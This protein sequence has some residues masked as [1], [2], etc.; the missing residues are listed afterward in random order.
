MIFRKEIKL[1]GSMAV[2]T[3]LMGCMKEQTLE[4]LEAIVPTKE[5]LSVGMA[6]DEPA[7]I[8]RYLL[9]NGVSSPQLS[10][11]GQQVIFRSSIT[12]VPQLWTLPID[13]GTPTQ[14]TFGNG[15]TFA[16]WLPDSSGIL[17]GADNNG[18]EQESYLLI[19]RNGSAEREIFSATDGGFRSL[20]D[21]SPD[22]DTFFFASTERTGL[23]YDIYEGSISSGEM[24][25]VLEGTYGNFAHALSPGGRYLVITETV[26]EDS[27]Y[28]YL[29]ETATG[30]TQV[31][32]QPESRANH[33]D[34]GFAWSSDSKTLYLS[35][36]ADREFT[37]VVAYDVATARFESIVESGFDLSDV[38]LCGENDTYLLWTEN[39]DG[40]DKLGGLN[41]QTGESLAFPMI[42]EGIYSL[43]CSRQTTT[44]IVGVNGWQTPGDVFSINLA[45][46]SSAHLVRS[47]LAGIR[48]ESLIRPESIKIPARD[49]VELQGLLYLP[50][51][52][53]QA[54]RPPVIFEVHGGPTAQSRAS[55][56]PVSQYHVARGV[57]V[58]K[59]N[60][61]GSTGFGRT[62]VKLDDQKQRLDSVRDLVDMLEFLSVDGRIDA[63]R[64]AVS[65]GSY[66]GY[67]VNAV[68][69]AYP[70][71]FTA[72]V[73]RYGVADWVTALEVASP[74]LKASDRIE[75]GDIR[76]PEWREFYKIN[77]PIRQAA[78]IQVPVLYSHGEM[79]PRIDIYETEVMVRTLRKNGIE[80]PYIKVPDEGHGWRKLSNRLFYYRHQARFIESHLG[81][82]D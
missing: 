40:F 69:A 59:P 26:G 30:E 29:L 20:G 25:L 63:T 43:S 66:G 55:F 49:G 27:D 39:Q 48:K 51:Q 11:D 64:A 44:L 75:Y 18:D 19:D 22:N 81:I 2:I 37:A 50:K 80:A 16:R 53:M 73:S 78:K 79:D 77:S 42:P 47:N 54:E 4:Q 34:G 46:G 58:F 68:L 17:Y 21:I 13:G 6:G 52:R 32:S 3:V 71:V 56:D 14:L 35:S 57:A 72:G 12:G 10:P 31:I 76:D 38:H 82:T 62:Y 41:L 28:L 36:N 7:D 23:H 67:M 33:G 70:E 24:E 1:L 9:A 65:G 5:A 60:V 74:A 15:I 61:R 45:E 8:S